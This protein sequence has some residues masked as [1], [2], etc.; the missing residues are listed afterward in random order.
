MEMNPP[1]EDLLMEHLSS[2][3]QGLFSQAEQEGRNVA[4]VLVFPDWQD[5][6]CASL[7]RISAVP[8]VHHRIV[9]AAQ[10]H[11]FVS[12]LK[13]QTTASQSERQSFHAIHST[14]LIFL[15]TAGFEKKITA[16][17]EDRLRRA[18]R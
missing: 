16:E 8:Y 14:R 7:E 15:H 10:Q 1:F 2:M 12:G 3:I 11:Q 17:M 13:Y 6:P 9:F 18:F 4:A 5:P